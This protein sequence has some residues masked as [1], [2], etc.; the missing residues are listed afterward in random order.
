MYTSKLK[1][2]TSSVYVRDK[3]KMAAMIGT[4]TKMA[5]V[6]LGK[7]KHK[8]LTMTTCIYNSHAHQQQ[9]HQRP[10]DEEAD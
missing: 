1:I 3:I 4:K 5:D 6:E 2:K 8:E 10:R 7:L 9:H